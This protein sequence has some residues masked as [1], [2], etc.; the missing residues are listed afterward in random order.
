VN[1]SATVTQADVM[2][3]NGVIHIIDTV[4]MPPAAQGQAAQGQM[5]PSQLPRA[6]EADVLNPVPLALAGLLLLVVGGAAMVWSP[7][8]AR[9]RRS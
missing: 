8:L 5:T 6:G 3:S 2:A 4:L 9:S 1:N 7:M